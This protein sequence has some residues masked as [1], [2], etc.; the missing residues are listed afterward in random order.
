MK[1]TLLDETAINSALAPKCKIVHLIKIE[2]RKQV[3]EV[4]YHEASSDCASLEFTQ[5]LPYYPILCQYRDI[6]RMENTSI[7]GDGKTNDYDSKI[8]GTVPNDY[9]HDLR[10][11]AAVE[12]ME[13]SAKQ[14]AA[15]DFSIEAI[16]L[17]RQ[18]ATQASQEAVV[19]ASGTGQSSRT[20]G[21]KVTKELPVDVNMDMD[22]DTNSGFAQEAVPAVSVDNAAL[23][24][25]VHTHSSDVDMD[26]DEDILE[27]MKYIT[28]PVKLV[29]AVHAS[30]A[31]MAPPSGGRGSATKH[32]IDDILFSPEASK[33]TSSA[34]E[35]PNL[36]DSILKSSGGSKASRES[37]INDELF[38]E[39]TKNLSQSI[40]EDADSDEEV[41]FGTAQQLLSQYDEGDENEI[42]V[43]GVF[44][45]AGAASARSSATTSPA[46][47]KGRTAVLEES[48]DDGNNSRDY[49]S[50]GTDNDEAASPQREQNAASSK[51]ERQTAVEKEIETIRALQAGPTEDDLKRLKLIEVDEEE[52]EEHILRE[53]TLALRGLTSVIDKI[54]VRAQ[55]KQFHETRR[56]LVMNLRSSSWLREAVEPEFTV[57]RETRKIGKFAEVRASCSL[58]LP[59]NPT[60]TYLARTYIH[61]Q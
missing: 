53:Q 17:A 60:L 5:Q 26:V 6:Y 52:V 1:R 25:Q 36:L 49:P 51:K 31:Q 3:E 50:E 47:A 23:L 4:L 16:Y 48:D 37:D 54:S 56:W 7:P 2:I 22:V 14:D 19:V 9:Y 43:A 34:A 42:D 8:V 32:Q 46:K 57:N 61:L 15:P 55:N 59:H 39:V 20:Y 27:T 38:G 40:F 58:L 13:E 33:A 29:P 24:S 41:D 30:P 44:D 35:S 21:K 45:R 28:S 12:E 10:V 11:N 18:A